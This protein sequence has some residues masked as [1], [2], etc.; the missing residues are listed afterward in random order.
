MDYSILN[1]YDQTS[2]SLPDFDLSCKFVLIQ[3]VNEVWMVFG[4]LSVYR[5]HANLAAKFCDLNDISYHW[6]K[7]PDLIEI[8]DSDFKIKGGGLIRLLVESKRLEFGGYSTAYGKYDL[9]LL[10]Q[11]TAELKTLRDYEVIIGT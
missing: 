7:K 3:N 1:L 10:K 9:T 4:A 2:R 6:V 11:F 5:Y 8:H